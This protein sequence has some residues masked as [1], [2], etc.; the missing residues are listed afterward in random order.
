M[1]RFQDLMNINSKSGQID[2]GIF[3]CGGP[4]NDKQQVA[5]AGVDSG[6]AGL[7]RRM[8]RRFVLRLKK[9]LERL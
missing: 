7:M 5:A 8:D 4:G 2:E 6:T 3:A 9:R 1:S